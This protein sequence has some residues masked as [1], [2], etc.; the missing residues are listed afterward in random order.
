MSFFPFFLLALR[1][2]AIYHGKVVSLT[3]RAALEDEA[4]LIH[5]KDFFFFFF[6]LN[7]E[8][9]VSSSWLYR[10]Q[11][12]GFEAHTWSLIVESVRDLIRGAEVPGFLLPCYWMRHW[13]WGTHSQ[14]CLA[15]WCGSFRAAELI[16]EGW[17]EE[18]G[19]ESHVYLGAGCG[20]WY[21][22]VF[23]SHLLCYLSGPSVHHVWC[24]TLGL[25]LCLSAVS[26][27]ELNEFSQ[28]YLLVREN[29]FQVLWRTSEGYA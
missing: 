20:V 5:L 8:R 17:K 4:F 9:K 7:K 21:F 16:E 25:A 12:P 13:G 11:N 23:P 1:K 10:W 28:S 3:P 15:K 22:R 2:E 26:W 19:S 29:N 6:F 24:L 27:S 14:C 18:K